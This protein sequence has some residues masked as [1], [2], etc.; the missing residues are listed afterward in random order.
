[1]IFFEYMHKE[2]KVLENTFMPM[3]KK[4]RLKKSMQG[5]SIHAD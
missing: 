4:E 5:M 1:M 2:M 3:S